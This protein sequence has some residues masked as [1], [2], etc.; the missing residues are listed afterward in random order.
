MSCC[1][2]NFEDCTD[3]S[4]R[5]L[6]ATVWRNLIFN[7]SCGFKV[8]TEVTEQACFNYRSRDTK[9]ILINL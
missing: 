6:S 4:N 2:L 5:P 7:R 1:V 3:T 9:S 8:R